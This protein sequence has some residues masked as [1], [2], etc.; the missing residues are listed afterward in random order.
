MASRH[1]PAGPPWMR[2][3]SGYL[4][5]SMKPAG[6]MIMLWIFLPRLLVNQK[7][8]GGNQ[9]MR[10]AAATLSSGRLVGGEEGLAVGR[11]AGGLVAPLAV[12]EELRLAAGVGEV[13]VVRH[14]R[15]G[16]DVARGRCGEDHAAAV[17]RPVGFDVFARAFAEVAGEAG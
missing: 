4:P 3:K 5:V 13:E 6:L 9:S 14:F 15:V 17:G 2:T 10:C 7:C 11:E 16:A 8:S 1:W 12:G